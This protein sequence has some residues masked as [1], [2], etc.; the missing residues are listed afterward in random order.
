VHA[1]SGSGSYSESHDSEDDDESE[2]GEG[3]EDE[4]MVGVDDDAELGE[5]D[6][7]GDREDDNDDDSGRSDDGRGYAHAYHEKHALRVEHQEHTSHRAPRKPTL[8]DAL[9]DA[10]EA[11]RRAR[12]RV[13]PPP[14][15]LVPAPHAHQ[16]P[17]T[18]AS[19]LPQSHYPTNGHV[20]QLAPPTVM[21]PQN[22]HGAARWGVQSARTSP[23][24]GGAGW[25]PPFPF[26]RPAAPPP[27]SA[28]AQWT[29][30]RQETTAQWTPPRAV[31]ASYGSE[32][33]PPRVAL[34][35]FA[36]LE[37]SAAAVYHVS[38]AQQYV[39]SHTSQTQTQTQQQHTP[40]QAQTRATHPHQPRRGVFANAGPPGVSGYAYV[41]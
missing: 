28:S 15:V 8:E 36:D 32:W 14:S 31:G 30:P 27:P 3:D 41:Y 25:S 21:P 29:P 17:V 10:R 20:Q 33:T 4:E 38:A 37:R 40:A 1:R 35:R 2:D 7:D 16:L 11:A 34:P 13:V 24:R 22:H 6:G 12:L 5:E 19:H 18:L 23:V 39:P 26:S 9:A